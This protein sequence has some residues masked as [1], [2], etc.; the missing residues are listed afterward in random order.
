MTYEKV[1]I[2]FPVK[3]REYQRAY[4]HIR[5]GKTI[6]EAIAIVQAGKPEKKAG[7]TRSEMK[8]TPRPGLPTHSP[9]KVQ[10][11]AQEHGER[12]RGST[13]GRGINHNGID[14][15][16]VV[17]ADGISHDERTHADQLLRSPAVPAAVK[18]QIEHALKGGTSEPPVIPGSAEQHPCK[19]NQEAS[20][21]AADL[22]RVEGTLTRIANTLEEMAG[23]MR[24][25]NQNL[26]NG[27]WGR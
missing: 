13:E 27:R 12:P 19:C 3:S 10:T 11:L 9:P 5:Q 17:G 1:G 16:L 25:I 15:D 14:E 26:L 6:D 24:A 22:A 18:A 2:P 4:Y 23:T 20:P 7:L 21:Q 8:A